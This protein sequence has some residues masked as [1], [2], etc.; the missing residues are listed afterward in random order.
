MKAIA[1]K[2]SVPM[3]SWALGGATI[4]PTMSEPTWSAIVGMMGAALGI[5]RGDDRLVRLASDYALAI[6]VDRAGQREY[7]FHTIQSPIASKAR[8]LRPRTRRDELDLPGE[9]DLNTS[10]TQREYVHDAAYTVFVVQMVATPVFE[11]NEISAALINPVYPLSA[12]RRS[13][14]I[15]SLHSVPATIN[16]VLQA[17]HWDKRIELGKPASLIRERADQL[18]GDRKFGMRHECVA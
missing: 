3:S 9:N 12:G 1:F 4:V 17:S 7:D 16:D 13:C 10:I 8:A 15:G 5:P 18:V 14:V 2:L 6:R 11:L